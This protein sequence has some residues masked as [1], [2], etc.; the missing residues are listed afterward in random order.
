MT[1]ASSQLACVCIKEK[2]QWAFAGLCWHPQQRDQRLSGPW[3]LNSPL[4]LEVIPPGQDCGTLEAGRE[5]GTGIG[6]GYGTS[7]L[8]F[9]CELLEDFRAVDPAH[10][11]LSL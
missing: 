1:R 8:S 10:L 2:S 5:V 9:L 11:G 7:V 6:D 4:F 3:R